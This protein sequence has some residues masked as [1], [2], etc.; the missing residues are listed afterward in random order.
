[1]IEKESSYGYYAKNIKENNISLLLNDC[2]LLK[3]KIEKLKK[4]KR[5]PF[6]MKCIYGF[7]S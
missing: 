6:N 2:F 4:A 3:N 5:T 7:P 1:L